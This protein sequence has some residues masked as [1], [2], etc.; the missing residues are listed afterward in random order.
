[1]TKNK[2]L[3]AKLTASFAALI[4]LV[5]ILGG[6]SLRTTSSLS[7]QVERAVTTV[8][9]SQLVAG[10]ISTAAAQMEAAER[11]IASAA[12]LQQTDKIS[13]QKAQYTDA[14][15]SLNSDLKELEKL[16]TNGDEVATLTRMASTLSE[17]HAK[18][19]SLLAGGQMD[20]ALK[21]FDE[22]IASEL[23]KLNRVTGQLIDR[24]EAELAAIAGQAQSQRASTFWLMCALLA[25][26]VPVAILVNVVIRKS[27]K[28]LR[29]L[30]TQ[31]ASAA[32]EVTEASRQIT[33]ASRSVSD[34]ASR[35]A[36]SLEETSSSSQEMSS[37]TQQNAETSRNAAG[38]MSEV[39]ARI[40]DANAT[41]D[42][43]VLSMKA[44][45][46]SSEKIAKI[47]KVID[48]ISFQTNILAL[49]AAV[50]AARAGE[51]GA[52][53][54]VVADE[55]RRLAQ[56]CAQ[57]AKDT[58]TLIEESITTSTEG[59]K[60]IEEMTQS[61]VTI[62]SSAAKVKE[63]IDD[64][65]LSSQEQAKGIEHIASALNQLEQVTQQAAASAEESSSICQAMSSQASV[66]DGVVGRLIELV[67]QS[68][69]KTK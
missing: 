33:D 37:L 62:T 46:G 17:S 69:E 50:E 54:A 51:A 39:D 16:Q 25:A 19:L 60:K 47:I 36:A 11:G 3:T 32:S 1:M 66:M 40:K 64:L 31:I 13:N 18:F 52:G 23:A 12:M 61:V 2:T 22:V 56:R 35:Q 53:F 58:A 49:N 43:M 6:M 63:L 14:A 28:A 68:D 29:K 9:R 42:A 55:V 48:E 21:L 4:A 24:Q 44:I 15:Q 27:T 34:G 10:R 45:G 5:V 65:S 41:L 59:G 7:A 26:V 30:T 8:A 38:L 20:V 67:G 57:A